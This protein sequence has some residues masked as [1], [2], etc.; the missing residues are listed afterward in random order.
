MVAKQCAIIINSSD[1]Q[2]GSLDPVQALH[3]MLFLCI[4]HNWKGPH[5][6]KMERGD[7]GKGGGG[8]ARK[9]GTHSVN[10]CQLNKIIVC[11]Q[12]NKPHSSSHSPSTLFGHCMLFFHTLC[13]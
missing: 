6:Y 9:M 11:P 8:I 1:R 7:S 4:I 5:V 12:Y 10:V 13:G 2:S 3:V